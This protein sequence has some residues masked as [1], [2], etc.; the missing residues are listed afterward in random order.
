MANGLKIERG[1]FGLGSPNETVVK[2]T[3]TAE[4]TISL[5]ARNVE[6]SHGGV[7]ILTPPSQ[8]R[9]PSSTGPDDGVVLDVPPQTG[10]DL[11]YIGA[12]E[13][14]VRCDMPA[15]DGREAE[16]AGHRHGHPRPQ[17]TAKADIADVQ[18]V[19]QV[20]DWRPFHNQQQG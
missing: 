7:Q 18:I 20:C 11:G 9:G 12:R 10:M 4:F 1:Y 14:E 5:W 16:D 3:S 8:F 15:A 13:N 17:G 19:V 2:V 6:T